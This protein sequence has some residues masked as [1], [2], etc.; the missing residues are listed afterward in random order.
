MASDKTNGQ[1]EQ[2]KNQTNEDE[3]KAEKSNRITENHVRFISALQ[4]LAHCSFQCLR[5]HCV[6]KIAI[7]LRATTQTQ[8]EI[9]R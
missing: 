5:L 8:L 4:Q 6:H 7:A 2:K 3:K 9:R 1:Q